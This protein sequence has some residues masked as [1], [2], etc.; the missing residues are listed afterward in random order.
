[1]LYELPEILRQFLLPLKQVET[2][3]LRNFTYVRREALIQSR[4]CFREFFLHFLS[5]R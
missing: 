2:S 5:L 1:M 3:L 4:L